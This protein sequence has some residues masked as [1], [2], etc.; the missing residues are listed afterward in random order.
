M[1]SNLYDDLKGFNQGYHSP[2][3][4]KNVLFCQ[5]HLFCIDP[6]SSCNFIHYKVEEKDLTLKLYLQFNYII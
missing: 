5:D 3:C 1:Y 2:V 6:I 4:R